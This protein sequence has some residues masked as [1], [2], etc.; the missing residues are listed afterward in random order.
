MKTKQHS[1]LS[2]RI[3]YRARQIL[4]LIRRGTNEERIRE[5][6]NDIKKVVLDHLETMGQILDTRYKAA[7]KRAFK[8]MLE[9]KI[10][11]RERIFLAVKR[12]LLEHREAA[13]ICKMTPA[14]WAKAYG[15]FDLNPKQ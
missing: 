11:G 7:Y 3:E 6:L 9:K 12:G 13:E 15:L 4:A 2:A 1:D 5:I 8:D 14:A 10:F